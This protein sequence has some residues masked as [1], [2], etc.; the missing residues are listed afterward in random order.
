M[1]TIDVQDA[2][3]PYL[4]GVLEM[5]IIA[6]MRAQDTQAKA[7]IMAFGAELEKAAGAPPLEAP[8]FL[9]AVLG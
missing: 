7:A 9:R 8:E 5:A 6:A 3:I 4:R 1:S 2:A